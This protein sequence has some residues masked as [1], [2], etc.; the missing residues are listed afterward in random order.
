M[1]QDLL[2][3]R[4]LIAPLVAWLIAQAIKT[5]AMLIRGRRLN[6]HLLVSSGG[7][8][9]AHSAVVTALATSVG[10]RQ[11]VHSPAFAIAVL[12]ASIV[13]YDAAG[14]RRAVGAQASIIN[15]MIT[16]HNFDEKRLAELIGHTPIQVI[17]GAALGIACGLAWG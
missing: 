7:M 5:L 3:N 14:V 1:L 13:M 9:S 15:R 10:L 2:S 6:L 11:G 17:A 4:T 12:F 8:P 16:D